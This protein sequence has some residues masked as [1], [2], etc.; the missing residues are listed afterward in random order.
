MV[1]DKYVDFYIME[2]NTL[3]GSENIEF[4]TSPLEM[5]DLYACISKKT[6][7]AGKK[8]A[9]S[10]KG[11]HEIMADGTLAQILLQHRLE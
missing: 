5:K 3:K 7:H 8:L 1:A 11:L 4:M 10:N 6:T 2:Q 9:A